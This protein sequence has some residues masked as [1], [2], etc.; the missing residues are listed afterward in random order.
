MSDPWKPALRKVCGIR[1]PEDA[2]HAALAGANAIGLIFYAPSP[3]AVTE[4]E[5]ERIATAVPEGV[6]RV[7]VFVGERPATVAS[8]V[9]LAGLNTVQLHG[10]ESPRECDDVR[11]AVAR[12]I[13]VWKAVRVGPGFDGTGLEAFD[14]DAFLL[15]TARDG[16]Y[17]GTGETFP[18]HLAALAKP[19]GKIILSGGLDGTN[20]AE[21]VRIARPWGIDSSSRL[22]SMPG[23]K[24]PAKVGSFL[25]AVL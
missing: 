1:R 3:R 7:G 2:R 10:D 20:A 21:A 16:S 12:G 13:E 4:A 23:V 25:R 19:H 17:G 11:S 18:W 14:V 15:D 8:M 9:R 5:A 22:E 24:D 6:R